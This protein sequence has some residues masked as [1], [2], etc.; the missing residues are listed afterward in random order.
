MNFPLDL[1]R[2]AKSCCRPSVVVRGPNMSTFVSNSVQELVN[3][4]AKFVILS[5]TPPVKNLDMH[6]LF[7]HAARNTGHH[8]INKQHTEPELNGLTYNPMTSK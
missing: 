3:V 7:T 1:K 8:E 5:Y 4:M 2:I 6:V